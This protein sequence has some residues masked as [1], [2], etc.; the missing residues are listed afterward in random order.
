MKD[1]PEG[2]VIG[3]SLEVVEIGED[4]NG[5]I[6][7]SCVIIPDETVSADT[8][9]RKLT[10][11]QKRAVQMLGNAISVAGEIPPANPNHIP[12]NTYCVKEDVWRDYCHSG[13]LSKGESDS[14]KRMA[15]NRVSLA[16]VG[17]EV[18]CWDGW[19]WLASQS[20]TQVDDILNR[21][22]K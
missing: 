9:T 8:K 21:L 14:A 15:F 7:S 6:M 13:G 20:R 12:P 22:S 2:A 1:G 5:K 10:Q 11:I 18:G 17:N 19:V 16:L 4:D 3:S